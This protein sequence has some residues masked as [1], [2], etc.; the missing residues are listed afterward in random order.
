[1]APSFDRHA[2]PLSIQSEEAIAEGLVA[3]GDQVAP[4]GSQVFQ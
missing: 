4:L 2:T 1:L 3:N